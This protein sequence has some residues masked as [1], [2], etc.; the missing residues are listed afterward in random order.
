MVDEQFEIWE[1]VGIDMALGE[2]W[3]IR[4]PLL[5]FEGESMG[6]VEEWVGGSYCFGG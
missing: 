5:E 6:R 4:G 2:N 1:E 3:L